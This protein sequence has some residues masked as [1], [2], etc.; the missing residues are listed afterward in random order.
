MFIPGILAITR[1]SIFTENWP[2]SL[3]IGQ[4]MIFD[5]FEAHLGILSLMGLCSCHELLMKPTSQIILSFQTA[6]IIAIIVEKIPFP[7]WLLR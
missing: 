2:M 6:V 7:I 3:D 5:L 1:Q 4:Y